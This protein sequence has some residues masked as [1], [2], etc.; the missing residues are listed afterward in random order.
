MYTVGDTRVPPSVIIL[1]HSVQW[2]V[3]DF[4][5]WEAGQLHITL[6]KKK[7]AITTSKLVF[8]KTTFKTLKQNI[9]I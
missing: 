2:R 6:Q 4:S 7:K 1:C 8:E 3:Q 9:C 5:F